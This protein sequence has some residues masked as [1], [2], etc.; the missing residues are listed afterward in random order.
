MAVSGYPSVTPAF[1]TTHG[2]VATATEVDLAELHPEGSP[3]TTGPVVVLTRTHRA[4]RATFLPGLIPLAASR[5]ERERGYCA[6]SFSPR[7]QADVRF[8]ARIDSEIELGSGLV[9]S[10]QPST[11]RMIR[12]CAK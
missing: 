3:P 8:E 2:V 1:V 7:A 6:T 4:K 11:G 5:H 12:K 10:T 9:F